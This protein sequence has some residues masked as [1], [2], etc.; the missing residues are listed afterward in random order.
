MKRALSFI[1]L[2]SL[3][4]LSAESAD[5]QISATRV[6]ELSCSA[7]GKNG[8]K[9]EFSREGN[10]ILAKARDSEKLMRV[11]NLGNNEKFKIGFINLVSTTELAYV[12]FV[13]PA[14]ELR[15]GKLIVNGQVFTRAPTNV[16]APVVGF[17]NLWG[18]AT[19]VVELYAR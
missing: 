17:G 15:T 13:F 7:E 5:E 8:D 11:S 1:V 14:Q 19:C 18:T 16:F 9:I 3:L 4:A 6:A 12:S 10:N 2:S